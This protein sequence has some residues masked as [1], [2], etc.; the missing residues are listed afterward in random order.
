MG[1]GV[2]SG[3][4]GL[5][6]DEGTAE[7][8][9]EE[10]A[11]RRRNAVRSAS[12]GRGRSISLEGKAEVGGSGEERVLLQVVARRMSERGERCQARAQSRTRERRGGEGGRGGS[13][14]GEVTATVGAPCV[15]TVCHE[16]SE[17]SE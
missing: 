15:V 7:A 4:G 17:A 9:D 2:G 3:N 8:R 12:G 16:S 6:V 10:G 11:R 13:A 1:E 14:T 5:K